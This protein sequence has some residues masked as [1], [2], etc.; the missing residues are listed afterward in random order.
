MFLVTMIM[1]IMIMIKIM[2]FIMIIMIKMSLILKK[3]INRLVVIIM[4]IIMGIVIMKR[5]KKRY[6]NRT[7]ILNRWK[8][9]T[10]LNRKPQ[11]VYNHITTCTLH[12]LW[13]SKNIQKIA[14]AILTLTPL[15]LNCRNKISCKMK[16]LWIKM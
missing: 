3:I 16:V 1:M 8:V 12:V 7:I 6:Q 11:K 5:L 15:L 14:I 4:M 10:M 13:T 9:K 2:I